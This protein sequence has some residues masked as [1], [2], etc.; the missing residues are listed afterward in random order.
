MCAGKLSQC[1]LCLCLL[2]SD[3]GQN[4]T[5]SLKH[6]R[7]LAG[8]R[9]ST[10][11]GKFSDTWL[12]Y[13]L[14]LMVINY[15]ARPPR[16]APSQSVYQ[17]AFYSQAAGRITCSSRWLALQLQFKAGLSAATSRIAT[18]FSFTVLQHIPIL[19]IS[20]LMQ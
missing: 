4:S 12:H 13:S 20:K 19:H 3:T 18:D 15:K 11:I 10:G 16:L 2:W 6:R 17:H 5:V 8:R 7:G 1:L 14:V 9:Q